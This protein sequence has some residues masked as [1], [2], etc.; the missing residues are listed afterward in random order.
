VLIWAA[1]RFGQRGA[2]F[3]VAVAAGFAMWNTVHDIGPF[4]YTSITRSVLDTQLYLAAGAISALCLAA[5]VAEREAVTAKLYAS[6][7]R[8]VEATDRERLRLERNLHDGAQ[9]TL[10]ALA[11]RLHQAREQATEAPDHAPALFEEAEDRVQHAIDELRELAH[12]IHPGVLTELG[13][14]R[15]IRTIAAGSTVPIRLVA[16][17]SVRFDRSAEVTAYYVVAEAV[18]N[19]QRYA[20]ASPIWIAVAEAHGV[21]RVEVADNGTGGAVESA[22]SGLQ[23][24]R[25]RVEAVHGTFEVSSPP[26]GGTRVT[27]SIPASPA[28]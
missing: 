15:A 2:T 10:T 27:A 17:P 23:G 25:D 28:A 3:A 18:T 12:G 22:G 7:S 19:A 21:L 4:V 26:G 8:L 14:A 24:L 11:F 1:L 6:R 16:L 20:G 9:Q 13:L 5:V